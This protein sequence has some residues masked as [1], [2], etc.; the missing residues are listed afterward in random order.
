MAAAVPP[1]EF[2]PRATEELA[3]AAARNGLS[4]REALAYDRLA[5]PWSA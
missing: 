1:P 4:R 3:E 5:V 2:M